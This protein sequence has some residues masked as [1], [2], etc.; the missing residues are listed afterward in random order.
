MADLRDMSA[1]DLAAEGLR[2]L[3]RIILPIFERDPK[4]KV[5]VDEIHTVAKAWAGKGRINKALDRM[6]LDHV[7]E[8]LVGADRIT[9][10]RLLPGDPS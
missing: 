6:V 3:C 5:P 10:Y 2:Q 1:E 4:R 8:R 9:F 7:V